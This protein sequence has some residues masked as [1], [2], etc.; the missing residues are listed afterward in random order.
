MTAASHGPAPAHTRPPRVPRPAPVP[1]AVSPRMARLARDAARRGGE[2]ARGF[3][4]EVGPAGSP[5]IEDDPAGGGV[6][7]TFLWRGAPGTPGVLAAVNKLFD[8]DDPA[9]SLMRRV[10]GTDVWWL[11]YRLPA[12]WRGSYHLHPGPPGAGGGDG[13][14]ELAA[15]LLAVPGVPDPRNPAVLPQDRGAGKSVAAMPAAPPDPHLARAPGAAA[16]SVEEHSVPCALPGGA[17]RVWVHTPPGPAPAGGHPVLVL[18]DG[19]IWARTLPVFPALDALAAAGTVPPMVTLA[20][21]SPGPAARAAELA[22]HAPFARFLAEELLPWASARRALSADPARTILAGQSLGGLAA[23]YAAHRAPERFGR[24][25]LQSPS[26]WWRGDGPGA[27]GA[28]AGLA[29]VYAAGPRLP[30]RL[31]LQVGSDEWVNLAPARRFRDAV[32][33]HGYPLA[34]REFSGGH[35][36]ACWRVEMARGLAELTDDW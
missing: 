35:D 4:D 6:I 27:P 10:D 30:L 24:V 5:L 28:G 9:A 16:G 36:R 20:V 25:L 19:D 13:P 33:A 32:R 12:D 34:Y 1:R 29:G 2:A 23:G 11:S 14:A 7:A 22:C 3:W 8:R 26:L 21:D 15:R 17:R 31:C 18:L